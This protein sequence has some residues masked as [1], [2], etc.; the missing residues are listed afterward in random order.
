M[1]VVA[2]DV[3]TTFPSSSTAA[4]TA[5]C[6]TGGRTRRM[7]HAGKRR[8]SELK[9]GVRMSECRR[10]SQRAALSHEFQSAQKSL[11]CRK[12]VHFPLSTFTVTQRRILVG[13][14]L[15]RPKPDDLESAP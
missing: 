15:S 2:P 4:T 13:L 1:G 11:Q 12:I 3:R 14:V 7:R 5:M 6:R 8:R 10:S 9:N